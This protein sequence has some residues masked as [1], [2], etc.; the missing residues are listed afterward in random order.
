MDPEVQHSPLAEHGSLLLRQLEKMR[1]SEELTDVVLLAEG[2]SFHCH[3]VVLSAFS[4]YFQA[5][6][7]CGLKETRGA[8]VSLRDTPAQILELLL[9]YMYCAE[10][11]LSNDNIQG[12]AAAAFLLHV[13]GAFR[14][15]Q[16]H[17]EAC[18]DPSNCIG[19]YH[20]ARDLGATTLADCAFRYLCQHFTQV[21]KEEE[22][23]ELDAQSLGELLSSDDLNISQEEVV[24][25]LVLRWVEKRRGDSQREAQAV[26]LLRRV[27]LELVDP[28]FLR[29]ARR[30]NPVLL[31]DAECFGMIDA[32]LQ[33]S[34]LCETSAP[35]RPA[36]RYGME[37]TDLLLCLGGVNVEGVPARRGGRADLSFCFAPH[38]RKIYYIPSPLRGCGGMGQIT[39]GAVTR[40]NNIVVAVEAEDQHRM[41]RVDIYGYK[42]SEENNW[43]ELCSAAYRDMY[44]LGLV[45]DGLYL[46]GG[47]MK[48]RNQ[49]AITNSVERWSLKRGGSWLSFSPLPLP[50]ACH[51][52]VSLNE[53][54][55]VLGG[56]TP[57]H[58]PD[59][60]P[61]KLSNRVFQFDPG[62]DRWTECTRMKYSRYRCGTAVLNGEI[63]VL[64][65]IGCDGEDRGQSRRCLSSVEIYNPDTDT[66]RVGPTLPTSLLSLRTNA[67]N[68]GVAEG[69]LY[70]CGYYKGAGR[71]EII[72][73]EILELD[74]ADNV[75]T[76]VER[77]A[78]MHDSYDVCLVANL[79]PRDL[80]TP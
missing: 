46:I 42:N 59:D 70:L 27:R 48:V 39:A 4:P 14:L 41:K 31:R 72:T 10:L 8:E 6:F 67:S 24:L 79:N 78:P 33:T 44:A 49:Y 60:E 65:G 76:V 1:A 47:Q 23:L 37:T 56:W 51:S 55:Y 69:K 63:Y 61:D 75:W 22:V 5:M 80:F 64:G 45:G 13:D 40:D 12:V 29:K 57:Q 50:L 53:H 58:Q 21:C 20:W 66:W 11:L 68:T 54:I 19:L 3:K 43:V 16:S 32:A 26:E 71:H 30:R 62:K 36:L 35:P 7:T 77:R 73:K 9:D 18:M 74:P 52:A 38:G 28:G 34:G 2:I 17:M 15:C 25:E